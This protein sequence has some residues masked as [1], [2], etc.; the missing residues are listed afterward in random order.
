[1]L[2]GATKSLGLRELKYFAARDEVNEATG[3]V[4]V[5]WCAGWED[6]I[7]AEEAV[8]S[9]FGQDSEGSTTFKPTTHPAREFERCS[10]DIL[11]PP[12]VAISIGT[13]PAAPVKPFVRICIGTHASGKYTCCTRDLDFE[14]DAENMLVPDFTPDMMNYSEFMDLFHDTDAPNTVKQIRI[15]SSTPI[16]EWFPEADEWEREAWKDKVDELHWHHIQFRQ[17]V[18][19]RYKT[20]YGRNAVEQYEAE[21]RTGE[22]KNK[23]YSRL[24]VMEPDRPAPI[25][26]PMDD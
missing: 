21:Y 22:W 17:F 11:G 5:R 9:L 8:N 13:P 12:F 4:Y 19:R 23:H 14:K 1:M 10:K 2:D 3:T 7:T 26:V 25:L 15:S 18:Y 24:H 20:G 16:E 6:P